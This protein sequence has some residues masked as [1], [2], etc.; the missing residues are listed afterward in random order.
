MGVMEY[1]PG[2]TLSGWLEG[3]DPCAVLGACWILEGVL[4]WCDGAR[5]GVL[6][7]GHGNG[8]V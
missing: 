2:N 6:A 3:G 7:R 8:G 5:F 4:K 1:V